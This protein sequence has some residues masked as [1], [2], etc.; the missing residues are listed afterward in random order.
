M[1]SNNNI[2]DDIDNEIP[3]IPVIDFSNFEIN[4][5]QCSNEIKHA[6]EFVGFFY[7]KNHGISDNFINEMFTI[8]KEF[9]I[10]TSRQEKLKYIMNDD[11]FGYVDLKQEVLDPPHQKVGDYKECFNFGK[12]QNGNPIAQELPNYLKEKST[13]IESFEKACHELCMKIL[14]SFA[15]SLNI[16]DDWFSNRHR[17]E[18]KSGDN[19]RILHYPPITIED[20]NNIRAGSHTDYG[21]LTLLFQKDIGGLEIQHPFTKKWLQASVI[22]NTILINIGD[23]MEFWTMGLFKSTKHRVVFNNENMNLHRYSIAYFCHAERDVDLDPIPSDFIKAKED[24]LRRR[25]TAGEHLR[26]RQE[27]TYKQT[28]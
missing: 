4:P 14:Q 26:F 19:F 25:I 9:F 1:T 27:N 18:M 15:I 2:N 17:Y 13:F 21:S 7:L 11:Y 10:E 16:K 8:A 24:E 23:L 6:C 12:F 5:I 20:G 22:P 28:Y 3:V